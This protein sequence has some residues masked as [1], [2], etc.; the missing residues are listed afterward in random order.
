[1]VKLHQRKNHGPA[2]NLQFP[3][4][5]MG[6]NIIQQIH[7]DIL[8]ATAPANGQKTPR[9]K[10]KWLP[11]A[12][13]NGTAATDRQEQKMQQLIATL[14]GHMSQS[15]PPSM[16]PQETSKPQADARWQLS[17]VGKAKAWTDRKKVCGSQ[18]ASCMDL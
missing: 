6:N 3:A 10:I 14:I 7:N 15:Q 16:V 4:C 1:M 8:K 2:R 9:R 5:D 18:L 13:A 12:A 17:S 11:V